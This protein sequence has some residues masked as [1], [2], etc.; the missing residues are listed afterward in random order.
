MK[1][2]HR[3]RLP[4]LA[5]YFKYIDTALKNFKL[6]LTQ[7]GPKK[8][9]GI[10]TLLLNRKGASALGESFFKYFEKS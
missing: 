3:Q 10:K 9:E 6:E 2:Y 7:P 1:I 4:F 8:L 5:Y